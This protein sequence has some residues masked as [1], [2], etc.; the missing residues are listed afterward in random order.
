MSSKN[1][2]DKNK[3]KIVKLYQL[4][5]TI[6]N[7][8]LEKKLNENEKDKYETMGKNILEIRHD[9]KTQ[10][11]VYQNLYQEKYFN[12]L[13]NIIY[14]YYEEVRDVQSE[15][16]YNDLLSLLETSVSS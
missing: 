10:K 15:I 4:L 9:I 6:Y 14:N 7:Y 12:E 11:R 3:K 8:I 16:I 1:K 13:L 2:L 5:E